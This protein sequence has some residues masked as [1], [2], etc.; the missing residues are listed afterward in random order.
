MNE[1][2]IGR[3]KECA[4]IAALMAQKKNIIVFGPEGAGKSEVLS[5]ILED[6]V[7]LKVFYSP[8]S[9]TL[10][11]ALLGLTVYASGDQK[12][13]QEMDTLTLKKLFYEALAKEKPE[14]IVFDHIEK[15][16]PRFHALLTYLMDEGIRLIAVGRG[17]TR[18]DV[19]QLSLSLF[20]FEKIAIANLEKPAADALV[21]RF[22]E[23]FGI[24]IT[25]DEEFKKEIFRFSGG[26]PKIIKGLC[27]LARDLKYRKDDLPDV[28]LMDLDR[29]IG[30]AVR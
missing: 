29:K 16:G 21:D 19:G 5:K 8:T 14:Y 15:V 13:I 12:N 24:K 7:Y 6:N 22:I 18:K 20:G 10:K 2:L 17:I 4:T 3:E 30:D 11:D 1:T 9:R 26:N 28:K 25:R 27:F 23:E